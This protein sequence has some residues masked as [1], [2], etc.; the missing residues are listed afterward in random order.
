M[1]EDRAGLGLN[2][3]LPSTHLGIQLCSA[4]YQFK[5]KHK[6]TKIKLTI[7]TLGRQRNHE[8]KD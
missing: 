5:S 3:H 1:L 8:N 6:M 4:I 2:N 7:K